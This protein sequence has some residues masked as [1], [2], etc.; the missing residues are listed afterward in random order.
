MNKKLLRKLQ[1]EELGILKAIHSF[2][3]KNNIKYSLYA[4][5]AIGAVRHGGFIPWD[6]D[7]DIV[8]TRN[9]YIEFVNK[10]ISEPLPGF[11]LQCSQTEE[12]IK[13]THA[14][15]RKNGTILLS[16][17]EDKDIGHHGIWVDIFVLDKIKDNLYGQLFI[18]WNGVMRILL[19]RVNQ[20]MT[21]DSRLKLL[22]KFLVLMIPLSWR[23]KLY[24]RAENNVVKYRNLKFGYYEAS[25]SALYAFK[26]RFPSYISKEYILVDFEDSKFMFFKDMDIM[27]QE[28]YGNYMKLP[29][30]NERIC[31]HNPI[32]IGF[33]DEI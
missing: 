30:N 2:C 33:S 21:N 11:Y 29:P 10:W 12:N 15:I 19:T 4:G 8:M 25:L 6:D 5:T 22:I 27:L 7:V 9:Y 3:I 17:G 16:E 23:L 20:I 31:R 28:I 24:S 14:K 32:K 1:L 13:I 18:K 26:Y